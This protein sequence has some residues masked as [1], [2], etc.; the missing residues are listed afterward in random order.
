[1]ILEVLLGIKS[2]MALVPVLLRLLLLIEG[3]M[4]DVEVE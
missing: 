2:G 1:M 4:L 3:M